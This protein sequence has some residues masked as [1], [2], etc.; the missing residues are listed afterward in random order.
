M[1]SIIEKNILFKPVGLLIEKIGEHFFEI[2]NQDQEI[3][4]Y[5]SIDTLKTKNKFEISFVFWIKENRISFLIFDREIAD[6]YLTSEIEAIDLANYIADLL[7]SQINR[8]YYHTTKGDIKKESLI[9]DS[10]VKGEKKSVSEIVLNKFVLPW[11][12][13]KRI[14]MTYNGW[15]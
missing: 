14:D 12:K 15:L 2:K 13:L 6:E 3:I 9:Y 5:K 1:H 11:V 8:I 7:S 4:L 10:H